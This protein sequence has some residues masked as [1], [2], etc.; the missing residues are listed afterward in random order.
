V[1]VTVGRPGDKAFLWG[2][3]MPVIGPEQMVI[4]MRTK[5]AECPENVPQPAVE[6]ASI[7]AVDKRGNN[8]IVVVEKLPVGRPLAH[9]A[10]TSRP[11]SGGTLY[12]RPANKHVPYGGS[13]SGK[14]MC[15]I[16]TRP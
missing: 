14:G 7:K 13:L 8:V 9:G 10:V 6:R 15:K 12:L 11:K 4:A 16:F 2:T 3:E 1:D 5:G